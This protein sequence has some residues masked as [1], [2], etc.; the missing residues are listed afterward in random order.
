MTEILK[1]PFNRSYWVVPGKLLAGCY[2]GSED[3]MEE[4]RNLEGLLQAGIRHVISLMET[5]EYGRSD[6]PF[7]PYVDH[8]ESYAQTLKISATFDQISIKD[9]S[10]PT[11]RQMVRVSGHGGI[12]NIKYLPSDSIVPPLK[13]AIRPEFFRDPVMHSRDSSSGDVEPPAQ[14]EAGFSRQFP[15]KINRPIPG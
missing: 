9:F 14:A 13:H 8:M 6:D 1:V 10:V 5:Q 4:E 12:S 15:A 7:P 11:K 3:P 2:P